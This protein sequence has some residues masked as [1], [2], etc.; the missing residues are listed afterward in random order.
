MKVN[1]KNQLSSKSSLSKFILT[2]VINL[3]L[4]KMNLMLGFV[5]VGDTNRLNYTVGSVLCGQFSSKE[6]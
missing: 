5:P 6:T 3:E 4:E 1:I 2:S